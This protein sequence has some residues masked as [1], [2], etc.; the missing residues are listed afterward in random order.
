MDGNVEVAGR[1]RTTSIVRDSLDEG[2][3]DGETGRE[4]S[5]QEEEQ[6]AQEETEEAEAANAEEA[7]EAG[8]GDKSTTGSTPTKGHSY[9]DPRYLEDSSMRHSLLRL[10]Q[11]PSFLG[12]QF[13]R[14]LND[15]SQS[16]TH[17]DNYDWA[18]ALMHTA[19]EKLEKERPGELV[20]QEEKVRG[21]ASIDRCFRLEWILGNAVKYLI[22]S[23]LKSHAGGPL[24]TLQLIERM[25]VGLAPSNDARPAPSGAV[26]SGER[27][28][29]GTQ[30][31]TSVFCARAPLRQLIFTIDLL[32]R[33]ITNAATTSLY[34]PRPDKINTVFFKAN[35]KTC[36]TFFNRIR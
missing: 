26:V 5:D 22:R 8:R 35:A 9:H 13:A 31:V 28:E 2:E 10:P 29:V 18:E 25:L 24:Q 33:F 11:L 15:I 3:E 1:S 32:E 21:L 4:G 27:V 30:W 23:N 17:S 34:L 14:A 20:E 16:S 7:R 19:A 12:Q 36:S 6:Q